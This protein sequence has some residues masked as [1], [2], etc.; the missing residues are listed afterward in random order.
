MNYYQRDLLYN[1]SAWLSCNGLGREA[2][3]IYRTMTINNLPSKL[4]FMYYRGFSRPEFVVENLYLDPENHWVNCAQG[5]V[6]YH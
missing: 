1:K 3:R 5:F 4:S 2:D 6:Y